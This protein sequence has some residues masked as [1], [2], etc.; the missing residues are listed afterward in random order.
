MS[1]H[2]VVAEIAK[3]RLDKSERKQYV[4]PVCEKVYVVNFFY[5]KHIAS[6][7]TTVNNDKATSLNQSVTAAENADVSTAESINLSANVTF[8]LLQSNNN[9]STFKKP[10]V[11]IVKKLVKPKFVCTYCLKGYMC[12][13]YFKDHIRNHVI[14]NGA[15]RFPNEK[16][17]LDNVSDIADTALNKTA[18]A[19]V[20]E[21]ASK[22]FR[23]LIGELASLSA[24]TEWSDFTNTLCKHLVQKSLNQK[25]MLPSALLNSLMESANAVLSN[26]ELCATLLEILPLST[27]FEN[28]LKDQFLLEFVLHF[29]S[30]IFSFISKTFRGDQR[31]NTNKTVPE[32]DNE[33]KEVIFYIGGSII[34]GYLR[35]AKRYRSSATWEVIEIVLRNKVLCDKPCYENHADWTRAIDRGGLLYP[36]ADCQKFFVALTEVVFLNE[37][38]DGSIEYDTVIDQVSNSSISVMWDEMISDAVPESVS[39]CLMNDIIKCFCRTCGR[40]FAK[41][42]L[43]LFRDKP[44]ISMPTR[45]AVARRKK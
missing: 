4:C 8:S 9:A 32:I 33:D 28:D 29:V 24:G 19:P 40:G 18:S 10:A 39:L 11:P 30:G 13:K 6:H 44:V 36:N 25:C 42:R 16:K 41:R 27:D 1:Y 17:I 45:H 21:I 38:S 5:Q 12:S 15:A 7:T 43:N 22:P 20:A 2:K 37:K 34:R 14:Q 31:P 3:R 35:I 26:N 23:Q